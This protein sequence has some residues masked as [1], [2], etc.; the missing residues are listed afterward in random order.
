MSVTTIE[1]VEAGLLTTVQDRGRHGFQRFGV[2]VSGALDEFALRVAN[3]LVGNS[4]DAA[5]LEITALGPKLRFPSGALASVTGADLSPEVNDEPLPQWRSVR[6]SP[7][8]ELS[9]RGVRD[10]VRSYLAVAGGI[11][12]PVVMGSRSTYLKGAIGG[13]EG[14][15]L[16]RGDVLGSLGMKPG[17]GRGE[18][19]LPEGIAAPIYGHEN[20][21]RVVLGPQDTAF[22]QDG[23]ETFLGSQYTVSVHSDRMGC[24]LEGSTIEHL[25]GAD[26]VSDGTALGSVQ[27]PGD[28]Q[29]IILLADRGTTGGYAKIATVIAADISRLAQAMPGDVLAFKAI[30]MEDA[31]AAFRQQEE[32]LEALR[33]GESTAL[34]GTLGVVVEGQ[35]FEVQNESGEPMTWAA[36]PDDTRS[37]TRL[38]TAT[39]NGR[40]YEFEIDVRP[41]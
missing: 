28:G 31:R 14:R 13:L 34:S 2:P 7:G 21:I 4:E 27:V 15:T 11:D 26:I 30:A 35:T 32:M 39:V 40:S 8:G 12:V 37:R 17:E 38:V 16:A 10:G 24:R 18:R 25:S 23:I 19:G 6:I 1:V 3:L 36:T 22:T 9:F 33:D 20:E 41:T 5:A 29:P